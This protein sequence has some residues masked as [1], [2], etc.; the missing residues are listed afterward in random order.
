MRWPTRS[1]PDAGCDWATDRK[2]P[3]CSSASAIAPALWLEIQSPKSTEKWSGVPTDAVTLPLR[4]RLRARTRARRHQDPARTLVLLRAGAARFGRRKPGNPLPWYAAPSNRRPPTGEKERAHRGGC[5]LTVI[6]RG[7]NLSRQQYLA[8]LA[9]QRNCGGPSP[10][11]SSSISRSR[12]RT[13]ARRACGCGRSSC[14][15]SS[16]TGG[17]RLSTSCDRNPS[18]CGNPGARGSHGTRDA[19]RSI[20]QKLLRRGA[21]AVPTG[22]QQYQRT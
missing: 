11:R 9:E 6:D 18:T 3:A 5:T 1:G 16:T 4:Q 21:T 7:K 2:L 14:P 8:V 22:E 10:I 13:S 19:R 17:R 20:R 12:L 15:R